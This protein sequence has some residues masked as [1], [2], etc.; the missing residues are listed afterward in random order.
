MHF[1]QATG[2]FYRDWK[3]FQREIEDYKRKLSESLED[4]P[5]MLALAESQ[6]QRACCEEILG[7]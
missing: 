2:K 3:V 6:W 4:A 5:L 1:V 7:G